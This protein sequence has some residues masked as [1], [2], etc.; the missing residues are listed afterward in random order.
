MA[1]TT[2]ALYIYYSLTISPGV[3][4]YVCYNVAKGQISEAALE[5]MKQNKSSNFEVCV[6]PTEDLKVDGILRH[7]Y[8]TAKAIRRL[9][10]QE[11]RSSVPWFP[12][13]SYINEQYV[14]IPNLLLLDCM[15]FYLT[16]D[17]SDRPISN[18]QV[19]MSKATEK[20]VVSFVLDII[21]NV[22][23]GEVKT[24]NMQVLLYC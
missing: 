12:T 4:V 14:T 7:V 19:E 2:I 8:Y 9:T 11:V 16:E 22:T 24:R 17:Q 15:G 13:G 1:S 6:L 23:R 3:H 10:L 20:R 5:S 18:L 21:C